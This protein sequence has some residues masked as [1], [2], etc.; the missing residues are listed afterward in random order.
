[1]KRH[2]PQI[3]QYP[4]QE[5]RRKREA[6]KT[7]R[8]IDPAHN[9][10]R[11][12]DKDIRSCGKIDLSRGT[13]KRGDID[14]SQRELRDHTRFLWSQVLRISGGFADDLCNVK[15]VVQRISLQ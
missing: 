6:R 12:R 15:R 4:N 5:E 7:R 3:I 13:E 9:W 8:M 2:H 1:M 14:G 10:R 11:K